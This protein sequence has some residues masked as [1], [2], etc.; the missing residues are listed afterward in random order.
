LHN[1]RV[2][3]GLVPATSTKA[4]MFGFHRAVSTEAEFMRFFD[5]LRAERILP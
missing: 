1:T 4:R 3:A 5:R 2:V